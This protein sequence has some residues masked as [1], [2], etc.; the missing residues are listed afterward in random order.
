[1]CLTREAA[2]LKA[3]LFAAAV[4]DGAS[5]RGTLALE[6]RRAAVVVGVEQL[7]GDVGLEAFVPGPPHHPEAAFANGALQLVAAVEDGALGGDEGFVAGA[8]FADGAAA[9]R[10]R[11]RDEGA[12]AGGPRRA[13]PDNHPGMQHREVEWLVDVVIGANL[14]GAHDRFAL[15]AVSRRQEDRCGDAELAGLFEDLHAG[16]LRHHQV[17]EGDVD[18]CAQGGAGLFSVLGHDDVET[19]L[20]KERTKQRANGLVVIGNQ[21]ARLRVHASIIQAL[22]RAGIR[23]SLRETLLDVGWRS[24]AT[25]PGQGARC[26]SWCSRGHRCWVLPAKLWCVRST[27]VGLGRTSRSAEHH[28]A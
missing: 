15:A 26:N 13:Q 16:L 2:P 9:P 21:E 3:Q 10:R 25:S 7:D 28:R 1:M 19:L 14:E 6:A 18:P 23:S 8:G 12:A 4:I 5:Q 22:Q 17:E 20:S 27:H 11:R 24:A